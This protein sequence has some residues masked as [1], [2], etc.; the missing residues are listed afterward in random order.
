[1]NFLGQNSMFVSDKLHRHT[2]QFHNC[3]FYFFNA[4]EKENFV[5]VLN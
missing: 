5:E 4:A 3:L 2:L 1:M